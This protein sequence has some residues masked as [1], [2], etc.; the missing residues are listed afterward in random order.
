MAIAYRSR[1][2]IASIRRAGQVVTE[3][4]AILQA[5]VRPGITT[6]E[7][8]EIAANELKIRG[9]TSNF[10]GY[11]PAKGVP[12]FPGI[13]CSSVNDEIVHGIPGKRLLVDGDIIAIDFGAVVDGWHGD[14]AIT[15]PV[16]TINEESQHLLKVTQEALYRGIAAVQPNKRVLDI[17]RAI[18]EYVEGEGCSVVRQYGG[19]GI[20]RA[21]HED[22]WIPNYLE[23]GQSNPLL[24]PG[25]VFCVEPMVN[26][27]G[28]AT[29]ELSDHWT[30]CTADGSRSAHYEH[31]VAV[32][33]EGAE[34]L[35][36][37]L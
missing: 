18:Q 11:R 8:D 37:L 9:A 23:P 14:S 5:A 25:M 13:I 33:S 19:H 12:P 17:S 24:R 32:T 21:L 7:L 30:V 3:I 6:G 27:G 28:A 34:I 15:V 22:P 31:T 26:L 4:L 10:K 29:R 20:G 16:G 2:E 1:T 36:A 35:T